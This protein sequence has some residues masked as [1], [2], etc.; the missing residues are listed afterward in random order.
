MVNREL[1]DL[2]RP[3]LVIGRHHGLVDCVRH[4]LDR[5][6]R[7]T[8]GGRRRVQAISDRLQ[9]PYSLQQTAPMR[10]HRQRLIPNRDLI[11]DVSMD[12]I[13]D[14]SQQERSAFW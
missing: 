10:G 6:E 9:N 13:V 7:C 4:H 8:D 3:Y 14:S 11:T 2:C 1:V 5:D 12:H